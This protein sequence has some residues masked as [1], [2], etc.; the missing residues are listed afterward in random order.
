MGPLSLL[1]IVRESVA[2]HCKDIKNALACRKN[3]LAPEHG[4]PACRKNHLAPEH[5]TPPAANPEPEA[6]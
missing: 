5:G 4:T 2:R 1:T 6:T 3:H